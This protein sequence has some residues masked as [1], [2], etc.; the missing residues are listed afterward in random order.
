[1]KCAYPKYLNNSVLHKLLTAEV[2]EF[3][4][5]NR[6]ADHTLLLKKSPFP[7]VEIQE[8]FQQV[9][10]RKVAEKKFPFLLRPGILFPP[11]LNLEQASSE[12]AARFK[13]SKITS[14]KI[15]DLT[16]G[17][18]IDAFF[19][20]QKASGITMVEQNRSLL[21]M[22]KHNWAVLG[23]HATFV[24]KD[25]HDFLGDTAE[26]FNAAYLDPARRDAQKKKVFL[27]EDLSPNILEIQEVLLEKAE[28][29]MIKLSP[30]IDI[31]YLTSALKN[32][33]EINI[34]AV[35][36]EVK[37]ILTIQKR[38]FG[39]LPKISCINLE[40][41]EPEF[42]FYIREEYS[43]EMSCSD[44]LD[45]L[46]IPNGSVLKSGAFK[47]VAER[48]HLK[49]LHQNTHMYT[50]HNFLPGFPGRILKVKRLKAQE[51]EKGARFN[52]ISKNYPLKPDDI[53]KKYKITDGG[54]YYLIFT[55]SKSGK[56]I[57]LS[58]P[59]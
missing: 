21:E 25:L 51:I 37:E 40:T 47:L 52:I 3:I 1:M 20:S 28:T 44:P 24:N 11:D 50:S 58:E 39:D 26:K 17:F 34:V 18:G 6:S 27:L 31:S 45:Y 59:Q 32:L 15:L 8:I 22:V 29:V 9:K 23:L 35:K 13:A 5:E 33:A 36:N 41:S 49:K 2:Q 46:Y 54:S 30:L 19:L 10:G 42:N 55:Q 38:G 53:K 57:L 48:F 43:A 14:G 7:D 12:S 16:A 4:A 56:V